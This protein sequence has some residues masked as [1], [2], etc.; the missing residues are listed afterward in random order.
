MNSSSGWALTTRAVQ[1]AAP[2]PI[3]SGYIMDVLSENSMPNMSDVSG[4]FEAVEK[5]ATMPT[6]AKTR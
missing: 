1:K 4:A 3:M 6:K 2:T 5:K